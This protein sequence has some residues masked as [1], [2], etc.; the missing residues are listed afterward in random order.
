MVKFL[1]CQVRVVVLSHQLPQS[2]LVYCFQTMNFL[3][4]GLNKTREKVE[5][6]NN[7]QA[8][9]AASSQPFPPPVYISTPK[10]NVCWCPI[11]IPEI[12]SAPSLSVRK[13]A[14]YKLSNTSALS[15]LGRL[16]STSDSLCTIVG[17]GQHQDTALRY[18]SLKCVDD[19]DDLPT[20]CEFVQ[21]T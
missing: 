18:V 13:S 16:W 15:T 2:Y 1:S 11:S 3:R 12:P 17:L 14:W 8:D 20:S 9:V 10:S 19:V 6:A 21:G 7:I 4:L 5:V